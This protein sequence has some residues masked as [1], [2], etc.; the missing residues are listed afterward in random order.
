MSVY[1]LQAQQSVRNT[2]SSPGVRL[3]NNKSFISI[4]THKKRAE[5]TTKLRKI[6]TLF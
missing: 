5:T 1:F 2:Q 6:K 3:R 4:Y